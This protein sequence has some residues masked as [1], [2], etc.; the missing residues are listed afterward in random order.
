MPIYIRRAWGDHIL[1]DTP[2]FILVRMSTIL[3]A[4]ES[5]G[6][7]SKRYSSDIIINE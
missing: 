3:R 5:V 6:T 1:N 4:K 7:S 2:K